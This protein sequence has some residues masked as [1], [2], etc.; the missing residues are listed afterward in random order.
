VLKIPERGSARGARW[1]VPRDQNPWLRGP[2][3][4][5]PRGSSSFNLFPSSV[6]PMEN[7]LYNFS[8]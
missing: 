7:Q 5:V 4:F 8:L 3:P 1:W 6:L 2:P